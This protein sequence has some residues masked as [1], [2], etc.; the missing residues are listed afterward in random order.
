M[1]LIHS[2]RSI[3]ASL[4]LLVLAAAAAPFSLGNPPR[5]EGEGE[6]MIVNKS[7]YAIHH[8]YLSPS[9]KNTWGKDQ[10][11]SKVIN[12]GASFTL[13]GIPCGLYDI[14]VAD[15]DGDTCEIREVAMCR[16]HTHWELTNDSL[17]KCEGFK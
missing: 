2:N 3:L 7:K 17:L 10:L 16:D 9:D 14:K 6:F 4:L 15:Q 12:P 8:L 13:Q 1:S 5:A 11:G